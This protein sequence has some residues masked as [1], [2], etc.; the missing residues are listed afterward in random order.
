MTHSFPTRRYSYREVPFLHELPESER[1]I[2]LERTITPVSLI[3]VLGDTTS[4][5]QA[6]DIDSINAVLRDLA[7]ATDRNAD[8][9]P[10]LLDSLTTVGAA[11]SARDGEL[12]DP[13]AKN[14]RASC[15]ER[16]GQYV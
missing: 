13:V 12:R 15:R 4:Q 8:V 16:V 5:I 11:F 7:G 14:G 1:R 2:P 3:G 9:V 10:S 6:I